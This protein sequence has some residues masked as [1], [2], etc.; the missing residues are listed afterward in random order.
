SIAFA[1][2]LLFLAFKPITFSLQ[3]LRFQFAQTIRPLSLLGRTILGF[4]NYITWNDLVRLP[5]L[6]TFLQYVKENVKSVN[7]TYF[8]P[9]VHCLNQIRQDLGNLHDH[10]FMFGITR[11]YTVWTWHGEVLD[12]PMRSRGTNYVEEWMSDHYV[13]S[14][15]HMPV[16]ITFNDESEIIAGDK[17]LNISIIQLWCM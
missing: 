14:P 16:Y 3:V 7:E 6:L 8:C 2:L 4:T 17:M 10:L 13:W 5:V 9:Y 15:P 11:T 1:C 12:Q